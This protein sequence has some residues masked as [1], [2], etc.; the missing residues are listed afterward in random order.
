M[1]NYKYLP[2]AIVQIFKRNFIDQQAAKTLEL[3]D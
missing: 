2:F 3:S 1:H